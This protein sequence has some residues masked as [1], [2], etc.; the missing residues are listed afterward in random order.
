MSTSLTD[1]AK[2]TLSRHLG[3]AATKDLEPFWKIT[4]MN[5]FSIPLMAPC[6]GWMRS[7]ISL[8]GS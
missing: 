4:G 5:R 7:V 1:D 3:A 2:A 8:P 6:G